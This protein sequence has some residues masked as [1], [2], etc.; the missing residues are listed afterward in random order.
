MGILVR[1]FLQPAWLLLLKAI[2]KS[3]YKAIEILSNL[4]DNRG[5]NMCVKNGFIYIRASS[6]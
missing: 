4:S 2:N 5:V 3:V 6:G 1:L